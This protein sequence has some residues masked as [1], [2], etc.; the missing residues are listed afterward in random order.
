[1]LYALPVALSS[2]YTAPYFTN[3]GKVQV[4]VLMFL[5][6]YRSK[7]GKL[8]FDVSFTGGFNKNKVID[9]SGIVTDKLFDGYNY[10]S[11][12]DAGFSLMSNQNITIT[13]AGLPFGSFYGYKSNGYV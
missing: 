12:G 11:N 4:K 3:I 5:L 6:G 13:K 2:G 1:M 10:Y 7:A 9:L 8:G